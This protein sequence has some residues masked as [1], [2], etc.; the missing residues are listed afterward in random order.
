M[1][2]T[3]FAITNNCWFLWDY[4]FLLN[5]RY[6]SVQQPANILLQEFL[7]VS[8]MIT[9]TTKKWNTC[10][11]AAASDSVH[12]QPQYPWPGH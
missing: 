6:V 8:L 11:R 5:K 9:Q 3:H 12:Y 10:P 2:S 4:Y 7:L 1:S